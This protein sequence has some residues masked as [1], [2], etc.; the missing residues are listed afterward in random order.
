M[1]FF[2]YLLLILV[3]SMTRSANLSLRLNRIYNLSKNSKII[4]DI[5][6]DHGLL[7]IKLAS[8]NE[9]VNRVYCID[10]S[11]LALKN[12]IYQNIQ[13]LD[14]R[15]KNKLTVINGDGLIPIIKENKKVETI[16]LAGLGAHT[17][18]SILNVDLDLLG[19]SQMIIQ[20][21]ISHK[22]IFHNS[23]TSSYSHFHVI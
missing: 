10:N 15:V 22:T 19:C 4:A 1:F 11:L 9:Q 20:V 7:A 12:G 6:S 2:V 13:N 17:I 18:N 21:S 23:F 16:I 3:C 14:N 8:N 5:G